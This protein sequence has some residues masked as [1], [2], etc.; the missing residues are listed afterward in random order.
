MA[1]GSVETKDN[2]YYK[3]EVA[4]PDGSTVPY[5]QRHETPLGNYFTNY[6]ASL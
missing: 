4:F 6:K 2:W 1:D 3:G 5:Y